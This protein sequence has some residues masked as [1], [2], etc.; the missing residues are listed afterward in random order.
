L[1]CRGH[2]E[3]IRRWIAG[4][5]GVAD[6]LVQAQ[7]RRL[8][9]V[10]RCRLRLVALLGNMQHANSAGGHEGKKRNRNQK[11]QQGESA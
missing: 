11:F 6:N 10:Q 5:V 3:E 1:R 2:R 9:G 7:A 4:D 8:E